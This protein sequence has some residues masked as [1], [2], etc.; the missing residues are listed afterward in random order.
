MNDVVLAACTGAL[1]RLLLSRGERPPHG[2]RAM[3]PVNVRQASEHLELG[4]KITS[5]FV[6]LPVD[7]DDPAERFAAVSRHALALKSGSAGV[8]GSTVMDA[9]SHAPPALHAVAA[10]SLFSPRLFNVT[11]TNV[12]GPQIPLFAFGSRMREVLPLVPLFSDHTLG[13]AIVSYDGGLVFGLNA[14]A[15]AVP[16]LDVAVEGLATSLDELR[17]LAGVSRATAARARP[18]R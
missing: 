1:R 7:V 3:V 11:I 13:V 8:G 2:M 4:N 5:L 15:R 17:A 10:R 16:D 9:L 6:E 18:R 14:D 12:P